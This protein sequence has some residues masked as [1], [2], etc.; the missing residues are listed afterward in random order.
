MILSSK[1]RVANLGNNCFCLTP[2]DLKTAVIEPVSDDDLKK[3]INQPDAGNSVTTPT[4][5]NVQTAHTQTEKAF[6]NAKQ[7]LPVKPEKTQTS[8]AVNR[9]LCTQ[10]SIGLGFYGLCAFFVVS[11]LIAIPALG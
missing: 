4:V 6:M 9:A 2:S 8:E 3:M 1:Y 11:Y 5:A 7:A 10:Q